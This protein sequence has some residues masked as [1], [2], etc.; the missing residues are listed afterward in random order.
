VDGLTSLGYPAT[1]SVLFTDG[2]FFNFHL[3]LASEWRTE[4][5]DHPC[6]PHTPGTEQHRDSQDCSHCH[7][8]VLISSR[9]PC[10]CYTPS[11]EMLSPF[12]ACCGS[13]AWLAMSISAH[14]ASSLSPFL[15][16]D[17]ELK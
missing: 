12:P 2:G 10:R 16:S 17:T 6:S 9:V 15:P 7:A 14:T 8:P 13:R 11:S 5:P 3:G 4:L 1:Q